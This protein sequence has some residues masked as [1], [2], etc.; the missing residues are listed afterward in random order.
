MH[1]K[2]DNMEIIMNDEADK[3]IKERFD[4]LKYIYIYQNSLESIKDS[5]FHFDYVHLLDYKRHKI[6]PNC[7]GLYIDSPDRKK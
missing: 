4:S 1:S 6:N 5:E 7:G 2:N 3:V